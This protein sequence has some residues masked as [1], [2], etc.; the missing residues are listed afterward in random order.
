MSLA[1]F[2]LAALVVLVPDANA[3]AVPREQMLERAVDTYTK[4][5][6]TP[7]GDLRREGFRS[8]ERLFAARRQD[9]C[10][11]PGPVHEPGK[12][13]AAERAPGGRHPGLS[14]RALARSGSC[15]SPTEPRPRPDP[16]PAVGATPASRIVARHLFLLASHPVSRRALQPGSPAVLRGCAACSP[17][18]FFAG[19]HRCATWPY[20]PRW[21][22][23]RCS[24]PSSWIRLPLRHARPW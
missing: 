6:D 20:C 24:P 22:G 19:R 11:E 9:G 3:A 8:A 21:D 14:P 7:M 2:A 1:L 23:A 5:L 16:A 12:R 13:R 10:R 17:P 4:A 15:A 18:R